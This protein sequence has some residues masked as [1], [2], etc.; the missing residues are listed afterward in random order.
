MI[1]V[2][3]FLIGSTLVLKSIEESVSVHVDIGLLPEKSLPVAIESIEKAS[4]VAIVCHHL[5]VFELIL[6]ILELLNAFKRG[7]PDGHVSSRS[8]ME[9]H[10]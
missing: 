4:I 2:G 3:N 10:L 9:I 5:L 6:F 8:H 7:L 1:I